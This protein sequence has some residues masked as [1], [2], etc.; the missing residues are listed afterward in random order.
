MTITAPDEIHIS[1]DAGIGLD[2]QRVYPYYFPIWS[3]IR[4]LLRISNIQHENTVEPY[5]DTISQRQNDLFDD[6]YRTIDETQEREIIELLGLN[7]EQASKLRNLN[8]S[9]SLANKREWEINVRLLTLPHIILGRTL[10]YVNYGAPEWARAK[11]GA[12]EELR[13]DLCQELFELA[14]LK[15]LTKFKTHLEKVDN[16]EVLCILA[17][18][19]LNTI[20]WT[21]ALKPLSKEEVEILENVPERLCNILRGQALAD[22]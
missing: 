21:L 20:M 16:I 5:R 8:Y 15:D 14:L 6:D 2:K 3:L 19:Y 17:R 4:S 22:Q 13:G 12:V 7:K 11:Y 9:G 10:D 1:A 18:G